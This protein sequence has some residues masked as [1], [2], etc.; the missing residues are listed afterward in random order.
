MRSEGRR[1]RRAVG[2]GHW[3][4]RP[5]S[6]PAR[7]AAPPAGD[8]S[9]RALDEGDGGAAKTSEQVEHRGD[10]LALRGDEPSA[11]GDLEQPDGTNSCVVD[12]EGAGAGTGF[13]GQLIEGGAGEWLAV[14][15]HLRQELERRDE[16]SPKAEDVVA[17]AAVEGILGQQHRVPVAFAE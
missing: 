14:E 3:P 12:L 11:A 4:P 16:P 7:P 1:L 17:L 9:G 2:R 10:L 8:R 5:G 13:A 15:E 6:S